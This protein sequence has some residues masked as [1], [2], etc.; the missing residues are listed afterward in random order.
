MTSTNSFVG[1]TLPETFLLGTGHGVWR[2]KGRRS[3]ATTSFFFLYSPSMPS[4]Q[5]PPP[6]FLQGTLAIP[7]NMSFGK[8]GL[9]GKCMVHAYQPEDPDQDGVTNSPYP[10]DGVPLF[11]PAESDITCKRLPMMKAK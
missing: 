8:N 10:P 4:S 9:E 3:I 5:M 11:P 2:R 1:L 6:G 7:C